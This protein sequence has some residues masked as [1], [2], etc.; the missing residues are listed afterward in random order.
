MF[1]QKILQTFQSHTT[2]IFAITQEEFQCTNYDNG[3]NGLSL[4]TENIENNIMDATTH[5]P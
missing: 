2:Q 5:E 3:P 1:L 4:E